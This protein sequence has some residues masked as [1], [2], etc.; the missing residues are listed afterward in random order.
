M[1][2]DLLYLRGNDCES[3]PSLFIITQL[4][5][6]CQATVFLC[7]K[8]ENSQ[9]QNIQTLVKMLSTSKKAYI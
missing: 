2:Y 4:T 8:K 7:K 6:A 1:R 9:G 3:F 5:V